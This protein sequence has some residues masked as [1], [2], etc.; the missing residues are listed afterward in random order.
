MEQETPCSSTAREELALHKNEQWSTGTDICIVAIVVNAAMIRKRGRL[1][2][3]RKNPSHAMPIP[4]RNAA[5][6]GAAAA[7]IT[8]PAR[9]SES[10]QR[11]PI[12]RARR[13]VIFADDG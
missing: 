4:V 6:R 1:D 2:S 11:E 9:A 3:A 8:G 7:R 12:S 5:R 10:P 13:R